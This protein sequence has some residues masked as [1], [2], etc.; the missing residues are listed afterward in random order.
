MS[1]IPTI[2]SRLDAKA[3]ASMVVKVDFPTP[4]L[5]ERIRIL[6]LIPD[7]R[8]FIRGI[9]GSGPFGAVAHMDWLGQPA[10]ASPLPAR[11]DSGPG[12]CST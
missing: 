9:S 7:K 12:Q 8:A 6:C 10:H 5:P 3:C 11:L 4:P 2:I 1:I